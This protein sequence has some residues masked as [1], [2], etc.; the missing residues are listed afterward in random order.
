MRARYVIAFKKIIIF[1]FSLLCPEFGLPFARVFADFECVDYNT[2]STC[3]TF[4]RFL[5][6]SRALGAYGGAVCFS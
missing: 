3:Y 1:Y 2:F 4:V 5:L 6:S